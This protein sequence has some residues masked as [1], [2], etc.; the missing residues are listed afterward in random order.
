MFLALHIP[1]VVTLD[2]TEITPV[3]VLYTVRLLLDV[4]L[5]IL[6][7][8]LYACRRRA[9]FAFSI[10]ALAIGGVSVFGGVASLMALVSIAAAR[11]PR[12]I[13]VA[14]ALAL[15][16]MLA[17]AWT[18]YMSFITPTWPSTQN[19]VNDALLTSVIGVILVGFFALIGILIGTNRGRKSAV[20][21]SALSAQRA[22]EAEVDRAKS[23]ERTRIAR[24]MH[25]ALAHRLSLVA[26]HAGVLE[27]RSDLSAEQTATTAKV[28]G[29]N[30]RLAL[31]ELRDILGVLRSSDLT[32]ARRAQPV[33][34]DLPALIAE[35]SE[36]VQIEI[37]IPDA[38]VLAAM[39]STLGLHV[40]RTVQELLTNH[41]KH[42]P[43]AA[44]MLSVTAQAGDGVSI[45]ASN[46]TL[47]PADRPT[48]P[49]GHGLD[50]I[51]ERIRLAGGTF[52][53]DHA[54]HHFTVE[55]WMPW[56]S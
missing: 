32:D 53:T 38:E 16:F 24:E 5:G 11:R 44:L 43:A 18:G 21:E 55:A 12:Q 47:S 56:Q 4:P 2:P 26:M 29:D 48:V 50:G 17:D 34:A 41:R 35:A 51:A 14:S 33:A 52:R 1:N 15:A 13:I 37:S 3:R 23:D 42:A 9:P 54:A 8:V 45:R 28:V 39:P 6:A 49:S 10:T 19:A 7:I 20:V 46:S 22:A 36:G 40:Y 25:D 30:S 31:E 27:Y